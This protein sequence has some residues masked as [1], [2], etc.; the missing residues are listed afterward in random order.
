LD[1]SLFDMDVRSRSIYYDQVMERSVGQSDHSY[2]HG[3]LYAW[4]DQHG[5]SHFEPFLKQ[6]I[7]VGP[8]RLRTADLVV[9]KTPRPRESVFTSP[10]YLCIEV[11]SPDDKFMEMNDRGEDYLAMGVANVW[12]IDPWKRRAWSVAATGWHTAP[13]LTLTTSD[14]SFE[15]PVEQV[16]LPLGE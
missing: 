6:D 15:L 9:V 3:R 2:A 5:S 13:N 8:G 14:G 4:F 7:Q 16:L 12:V 11:A 1:D 10:P